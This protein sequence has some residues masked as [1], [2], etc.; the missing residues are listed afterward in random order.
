FLPD[1][2]TIVAGVVLPGSTSVS[3]AT[4]TVQATLNKARPTPPGTAVEDLSFLIVADVP[5]RSLAALPDPPDRPASFVETS[6]DVRA[7]NMDRG[8]QVT[9]VFRYQEGTSPG[10][11]PV[12]EFFN[13]QTKQFELVR[14][15]TI[16]PNS[17]VINRQAQTVTLIL[18]GTS[19]P[20][21]RSLM[22]MVFTVILP[23]QPPT[24]VTAQPSPQVALAATRAST[25]VSDSGSGLGNTITLRTSSQ[26][27]LSL[28]P[29]TGGQA[30]D[31]QL[32]LPSGGGGDDVPPEEEVPLWK[33][34]LEIWR[35][36]RRAV[37]VPGQPDALAAPVTS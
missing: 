6:Y 26:P 16:V 3:V 31:R 22:G 19:F 11:D 25:T 23:T 35:M 12:I 37:A 13:E 28:T 14:G 10:A 27:T 34:L 1:I 9:I 7:I 21:V 2:K 32:N 8:D 24:E 18:D 20:T 5:N 29:T 15:S 30:G 4:S 33:R 17:L 36:L